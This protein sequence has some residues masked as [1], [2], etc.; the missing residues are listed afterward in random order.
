MDLEELCRVPLIEIAS[1]LDF[2][3]HEIFN[4]RHTYVEGFEIEGLAS[5]DDLLLPDPSGHDEI[6]IRGIVS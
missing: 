1:R 4:G 6:Y 3:Q 2:Q 5:V